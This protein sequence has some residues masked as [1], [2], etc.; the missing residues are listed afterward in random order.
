MDTNATCGTAGSL[1]SCSMKEV[2][3]SSFNTV[4]GQV[5]EMDEPPIEHV[6][7]LKSRLSNQGKQSFSEK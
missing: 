4:L 2:A 5:I 1:L 7:H 3:Q 6:E